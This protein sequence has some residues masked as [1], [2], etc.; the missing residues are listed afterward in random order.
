[1]QA[2]LVSLCWLVLPRM[3][4][5]CNKHFPLYVRETSF[6]SPV[7]VSS[8]QRSNSC[9]WIHTKCLQSN[10]LEVSIELQLQWTLLDKLVRFWGG[11]FY[12]LL[13]ARYS[14]ETYSLLSEKSLV[15]RC[16]TCSLSLQNLLVIIQKLTRYH[17]KTYSLSLKSLL[18]I[19]QNLLVVIQNL[20]VMTENLNIYSLWLKIWMLAKIL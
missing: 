3:T 7:F 18:V 16:I 9:P 19:I 10:V 13:V 2:L 8:H 1:M 6:P 11:T 4:N 12:S 17:F 15:T 14:L 5:I 20:L